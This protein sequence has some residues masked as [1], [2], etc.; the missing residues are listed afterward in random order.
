MVKTWCYRED[1]SYG[2]TKRKNFFLKKKIPIK[3]SKKKIKERIKS[4]TYHV[5]RDLQV[6]LNYIKFKEITLI[7]IS[8]NY[9]F[10]FFFDDFLKKFS[11]FS[12]FSF[13]ISKKS[14]ARKTFPENDISKEREQI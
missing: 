14:D 7:Y 8:Y 2:K 9:S 4:K 12:F 5:L 13:F 1:T 6:V 10:F 11:F 3:T